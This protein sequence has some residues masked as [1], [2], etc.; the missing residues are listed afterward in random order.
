MAFKSI[1]IYR[2]ERQAGK[3][4]VEAGAESVY[5]LVGYYYK[6]SDTP[7]ELV[8][9]EWKPVMKFTKYLLGTLR[10]K[11]R[12]KHLERMEQL[13]LKRAENMQRMPAK[14]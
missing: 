11:R 13:A 9:P 7:S 5:S 14:A 4:R 8:V 10:D 6:R 12:V 1:P 2:D 3:D